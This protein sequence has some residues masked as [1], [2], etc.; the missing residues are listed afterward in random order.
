MSTYRQAI[1]YV[2]HETS[3]QVHAEPIRSSYI[4]SGS[5]RTAKSGPI[6]SAK[7]QSTLSGSFTFVNHDRPLYRSSTFSRFDGSELRT[8]HLTHYAH[9]KLIFLTVYIKYEDHFDIKW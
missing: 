7:R 4:R 1:I 9:F 2:D 8:I 5:K 6:K 3:H